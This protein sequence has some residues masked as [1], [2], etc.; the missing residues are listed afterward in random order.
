VY[1]KKIEIRGIGS[2]LLEKAMW[3]LDQTKEITVEPFR[4]NYRLGKPARHVYKKNLI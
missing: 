4:E 2:Q 3:E 1:L